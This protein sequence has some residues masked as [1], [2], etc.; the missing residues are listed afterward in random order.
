MLDGSS[1]NQ[2]GRAPPE[3]AS[4]QVAMSKPGYHDRCKQ[5]LPET[6]ATFTAAELKQDPL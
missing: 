3:T 1:L 5:H 4:A 6:G 2:A